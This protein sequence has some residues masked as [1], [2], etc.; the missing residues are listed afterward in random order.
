VAKLKVF[1]PT[2]R[3][4]ETFKRSI[5]SLLEQTIT[6]WVCEVHN[7]DPN[8]E[9][10]KQFISSLRDKRFTVTDHKQNLGPLKTFNLMFEPTGCDYICLLEDDNWWEP[11]FL[12]TMLKEMELNPQCHI[13]YSRIRLWQ[14][15]TDGKWGPAEDQL[16]STK[17][18][19]RLI[20]FPQLRHIFN[21]HHSNCSMMI[22]NMPHL[23]NLKVPESSRSDFIEP[24]RERAFPH[25]ILFVNEPLANFA[26]TINTSRPDNLKGIYE[27]YLLLID[28]FFQNFPLTDK[29]AKALWEDV[30][31]SPQ[32]SFNKLIY[33]GLFCKASRGLLK[34]AS[35]SEWIYFISYN[36]KRPSI[37]F[38]CLKAKKTYAELWEYLLT[39]TR[40]RVP[41]AQQ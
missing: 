33:T 7:D 27:H 39:N 34:Y 14:E 21:Y 4:N 41:R 11:N 15:K 31:K 29:W 32:K 37:F 22:M 30:R 5:N 18:R 26:L 1:A 24:V 12:F 28:S 36:I 20:S 23:E 3:R 16:Q 40:N 17:E 19:T 25:P 13:G 9:F 10:P 35:T 2:Y 6:D 8:D 38:S